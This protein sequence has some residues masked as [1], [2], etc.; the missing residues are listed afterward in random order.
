MSADSICTFKSTK[1]YNS[2]T[3]LKSDVKYNLQ[4]ITKIYS[5]LFVL[6][7]LLLFCILTTQKQMMVTDA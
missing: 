1:P 7:L 4:Q 6:L 3:H 2:E 5:F